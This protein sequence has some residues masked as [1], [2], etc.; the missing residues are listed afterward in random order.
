MDGREWSYD[1]WEGREL[2]QMQE[3]GSYDGFRGQM[4]EKGARMDGNNG[5]QDELK[6]REL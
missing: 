3:G 4:K 1:E 6:R 5:S 2:G